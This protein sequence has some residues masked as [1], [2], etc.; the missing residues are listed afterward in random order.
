M[1]QIQGHPGF[2]KNHTGVIV[3]R[4]QA[5]RRAYRQMKHQAM[6][7]LEAQDEIVCLREELDELKDLVKQLIQK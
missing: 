5:E 2:Y 6:K 3:N 7:Q 1:A 4:S